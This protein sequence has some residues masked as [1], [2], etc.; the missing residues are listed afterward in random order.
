MSNHLDAIMPKILARGMLA[1]RETA[2]MPRLVN[3]D[4]SNEAAQKGASVDIMIPGE[5]AV[6]DVIPGK[7]APDAPDTDVSVK[8]L[9]LDHW[10]KVAF[11]LTDK[12]LMQIEADRDFVPFKMQEAVHAL[13]NAINQSFYNVAADAGTTLYDQHHVFFSSDPSKANHEH[14]GIKLPLLVR[15]ILNKQSAPKQ[16]R[17]GI[18]SFEDEAMMLAL[19]QFSDVASAGDDQVKREGEIGRK[20]GIDWYS[21]DLIKTK[22]NP[23]S[24]TFNLTKAALTGVKNIQVNGASYPISVGDVIVTASD[25]EFISVVK[26]VAPLNSATSFDLVVSP[27]TTRNIASSVQMKIAAQARSNLA[28]QRDAFAF[29]TRPLS[30][31]SETMGLGNR[32]LSVT[33]PETG[34]TLRLEI[35]RQYKRTL[36]EFDVLWGV[37]LVRPEWAI[38][39][40]T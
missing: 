14:A 17:I 9:T 24:D 35:S 26:K 15:E 18:V 12:D 33:D 29:A 19:P 25:N 11:Y 5:V 21:S 8:T 4:F 1:F 2:I 10:K 37:E 20:F 31:M 39:L 13:A 30:T 16:G 7:D 32:I 28:F 27:H 6:E 34:L 23:T 36:W 3:A 40:I 22:I 38:R